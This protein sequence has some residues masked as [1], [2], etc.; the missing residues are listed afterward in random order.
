MSVPQ[1]HYAPDEEEQ[2]HWWKCVKGQ[3]S[4][5]LADVQKPEECVVT[6]PVCAMSAQSET[7]ESRIKQNQNTQSRTGYIW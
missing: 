1:W 7:Q 6:A 4:D 5:P 3:S 2:G